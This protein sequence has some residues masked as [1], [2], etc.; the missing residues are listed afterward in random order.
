MNHVYK[1]VFNRSLGVWQAV[2]ELARGPGKAAGRSIAGPSACGRRLNLRWR[3]LALAI[4]GLCGPCLSVGMAQAQEILVNGD[5]VTDNNTPVLVGPDSPWN[6]TTRLKVGDTGSGGL[7]LTEGGQIVSS[8]PI[9]IGSSAGSEGIITVSGSNPSGTLASTLTGG[10]LRAGYSGKGTLSITGGGQVNAYSLLAGSEAGSHGIVEVTGPGS[11]INAPNL[12]VGYRGAGEMR[13]ADGGEVGSTNSYAIIGGIDA[14][15]GKVLVE[16][17]GSTFYTGDMYL[18]AN[19]VGGNATMEV[20][21]GGTVISVGVAFVS[22][23]TWLTDRNKGGNATV[24]VEGAGSSWIHTG[25][26]YVAGARAS[27]SRGTGELTLTNGGTLTS[28]GNSYIGVHVNDK[29]AVWVNGAGDGATWTSTG[30]LSVGGQ[31]EGELTISDGGLVT[32]PSVTVSTTGGKGTLTIGTAHGER[33]VAPGTLDA[34]SVN[35]GANGTLAF[36]HADNDGY[37]FAPQIRGAGAVAQRAGSTALTGMSSAFSGTTTV[38]GGSLWVDGSLGGQSS[39]VAVAS[40]GVLGGSGII[41]GSVHVADGG[42]LSPGAGS[43]AAG[44]LT[45]GSLTLD[46]G[47]ILNYDLGQAEVAGGALN[48]LTVVNG[49][50]ALNGTLNVSTTPAGDFLPG[51]YRIFNYTGALTDGGIRV[52]TTPISSEQHIQT[53]VSKQVNLMVTSVGLPLTF[54]DGDAGPQ[55]DGTVN[56]GDGAWRSGAAYMNWTDHTGRDVGFWDDG[57][58]AVF[59]G[60]PGAVT[61]DNSRGPVAAAGIQF[62]SDGYRLNGGELALVESL[63]DRAGQAVIRVGDGSSFGA[64]YTATIDSKVSGGVQLVK[65]DLG[66]LVLNGENTYAGGTRVAGGTLSV[67]ADNNLGEAGGSLSLDGGALNTSADLSTGRWVKLGARGGIFDVD[68]ETTLEVSGMLDGAGSLTKSNAGTLLI[69]GA[70]NVYAGRSIILGGTLRAGGVD[71]FS[72]DSAV[73]VGR[74]GT[75]DLNGRNQT[76]G[77]LTNA[78]K[79][80]MG[81]VSGTTLTVN[82]DYAG[83]NGV[84]DMNTVLGGASSATDLLHVKGRTSGGTA[85]RVANEGGLGALTEGNGIKVVQV[86]GASNGTFTTTNRVEAGAY[87][88]LLYQGGANGDASDGNWY[89]RSHLEGASG[90]PGEG[91]PEAPLAYRPGVVGYA[92]TPALN[93]D[94]GFVNL[95]R[96]H[97]RVGDVYSAARTQSGNR[98]GVWGRISGYEQKADSGSRFSADQNTFFTQFGKDWTLAERQDGS[99]VH[100]GVTG[101]LGESDIKF[102]DSA[103]AMNNM[104]SD[105]TGKTKTQSQSVGGYYTRYA[106]DGSYWD[107]AAQVTRYRN[108]Y[109]DVYGHGATQDGVGVALSQEVGRPFLVTPELA[110]EPQAQLVYQNLSLSGFDEGVSRVSGSSNDAVRG[111]LGVRIF[112]PNAGSDTR[113]NSTMPYMTV[114]VLHDFVQPKAV[115]VGGTSVRS[116]FNRTWGEVGVGLNR[117]FGKGSQFYAGAKLTK[118]LGGDDKRG[119]AGQVGYRYSW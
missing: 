27:G 58:F 6:L 95:G 36:F 25:D 37:Q 35:L 82:G 104:L 18:A 9:H 49:D 23:E 113:G 61:V 53:S 90:A 48:D 71:A 24:T 62:A 31:G 57:S 75:L 92:L 67:S 59:Q 87:E 11:R 39:S 97:E 3:P 50:L 106:D 109:D 73:T 98:D 86:D 16:G 115:S 12:I 54:W 112:A 118:N 42:I 72:P 68:A 34:Q 8:A 80:T 19:G 15:T 43:G 55:G 1:N 41:G 66:T 29:G 13:I 22:G 81:T 74:A 96:L 7:A 44:T 85:L 93:L 114:D 83:E 65:E 117:G 103:R 56:G 89:L 32:A 38:S 21:N 101:S 45:T 10:E 47:A 4:A 33:P 5:V 110:V 116:D 20:R 84:I 26:L 51:V 63:P 111:R 52:G 108:R 79:V 30:G 28:T 64:A 99:R 17:A 102:E 107:S 88:Y 2:S 91:K 76:I 70:G 119:V 46:S 78:G 77:G 69:S 100:A 105:R 94:Y 40:G 60:T 14:S